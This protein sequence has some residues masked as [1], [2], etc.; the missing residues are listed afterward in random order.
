E[1]ENW[2]AAS[3][4]IQHNLP[5]IR[6]EPILRR[7]AEELSPGCVRFHHELLSLEQD[8]EQVTAQVRDH[9]IGRDYEVRCEYLIGAD[10]GRRVA[11]EVGVSYE[12]LGVV[13]QAATLHV[14]ADFSR[15]APD[16]DV[17]IRWIL[18]PQSG[19]GV[20]MVPMGPERW[21]PGSEE[22]VIHVNYPLD[23]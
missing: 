10:G 11:Q 3:P 9:D 1:D 15:W 20:V 21:G 6:L 22:W 19:I 4:W 16:P 13:S 23:D 7:R 12:G 17:L 8:D 5:Q 18:S 14:T 2:R